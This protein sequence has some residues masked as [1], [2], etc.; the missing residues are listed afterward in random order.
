MK[1]TCLYRECYKRLRH[2]SF[3]ICTAELLLNRHV[4]ISN[5]ILGDGACSDRDSWTIPNQ[6]E[7]EM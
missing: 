5:P 2:S 7:F 1:I 6:L 4:L 3:L